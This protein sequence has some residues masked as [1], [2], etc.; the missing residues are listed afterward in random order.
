MHS[1]SLIKQ[2]P[3]TYAD[4]FLGVNPV[5]RV[6]L[7]IY[8]CLDP[9]MEPAVILTFLVAYLC[10]PFVLSVIKVIGKLRSGPTSPPSVFGSLSLLSSSL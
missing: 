4:I 6:W 7:F 3:E 9:V 8:I 2:K 1:F 10:L 5:P